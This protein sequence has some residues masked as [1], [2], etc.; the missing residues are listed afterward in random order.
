[1]KKFLYLGVILLM[2]ASDCYAKGEGGASI[3]SGFN[4]GVGARA[5]ALA[6][7]YSAVA[8][9]ATG[10]Y[11][12]PAGLV[13]LSR[14]ELYLGYQ[15]F[16]VDIT[17][18][19]LSY[20]QQ[21]SKNYCGIS[22]YLIDYGSI[23]RTEEQLQQLQEQQRYLPLTDKGRY[24]AKEGYV[25]L[26][27]AGKINERLSIGSSIKFL[28]QR[29]D[30]SKIRTAAVD[31]GSLYRINNNLRAA[32]VINNIGSRVG[33][34]RLQTN[35]KLGIAYIKGGRTKRILTAADAIIYADKRKPEINIGGELSMYEIFFLRAGYKLLRY[36]GSNEYSIGGG[37]RL[38]KFLQIDFVFLPYRTLVENA[39]NYSVLLRF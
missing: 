9:D 4:L 23:E 29:I 27:Y 15:R 28:R 21:T 36:E 34:D 32:I 20:A 39:Y 26:S 17:H 2:F 16:V 19:Y 24:T 13:N 10:V 31:I 30:R 8:D 3:F 1:M 5:K 35:Y 37:I 18:Q 22:L 6:D 33:E 11:W 38:A 7:A 25:S 12:N 14:K